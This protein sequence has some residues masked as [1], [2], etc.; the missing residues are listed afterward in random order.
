MG[1]SRSFVSEFQRSSEFDNSLWHRLDQGFDFRVTRTF[2][3]CK[4]RNCLSLISP[5]TSMCIDEGRSLHKF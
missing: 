1:K 3:N 5:V 2:N 4:V